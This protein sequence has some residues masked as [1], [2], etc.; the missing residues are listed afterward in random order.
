MAASAG[1]TVIHGLVLVVPVLD[2][3]QALVH[4]CVEW[5]RERPVAPVASV[6]RAG[7]A[8]QVDA[9]TWRRKG[10]VEKCSEVE[11]GREGAPAEQAT[12]GVVRILRS[13]PQAAITT[14]EP[15]HEHEGAQ[16]DVVV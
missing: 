4:R 3:R 12:L 14:R 7:S 1:R 16:E 6:A 15:V 9:E 2:E 13:I 11:S 5:R 10:A 8:D